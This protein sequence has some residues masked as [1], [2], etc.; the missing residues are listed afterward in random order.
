MLFSRCS[1]SASMSFFFFLNTNGEGYRCTYMISSKLSLFIY[2]GILPV[3]NAVISYI[4]IQDPLIFPNLRGQSRIP[5][6]FS[7]DSPFNL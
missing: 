1:V 5:Y 7:N 3:S 2:L 6:P 4:Q